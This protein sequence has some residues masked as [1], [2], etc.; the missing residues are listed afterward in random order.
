MWCH[1]G[2]KS[3]CSMGAFL[4]NRRSPGSLSEVQNN[5]TF[6][7]GFVGMCVCKYIHTPGSWHLGPRPRS[8]SHSWMFRSPGKLGWQSLASCSAPPPQHDLPHRQQRSLQPCCLL[9]WNW[10]HSGHLWF[11]S[12]ACVWTLPSS[13]R[14]W[15]GLSCGWSMSFN[16]SIAEKVR[17]RKP[18]ALMVLMSG[19]MLAHLAAALNP[20]RGSTDFG[21]CPWLWLGVWHNAW[22]TVNIQ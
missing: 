15:W 4:R 19:H 11:H 18:S 1:P 16:E 7:C 2:L 6:F 21:P 8:P 10:V 13:K 5:P 9:S 12:F 17:A 20:L 3:T 22:Y 14:L